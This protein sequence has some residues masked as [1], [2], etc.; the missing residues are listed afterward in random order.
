MARA[1]PMWL[2]LGPKDE[3]RINAAELSEKEL[4]DEVH[5]LTHFSQEDSIPLTSSHVPFDADHPP[6]EN[7]IDPDYLQ[8]LPNDTSER[9]DSSVP[10]GSHTEGNASSKAEHADPIN[11]EAILIDPKSAAN[12][13]SDTAGSM[14]DDDADHAAFVDAAAEEAEALPSKRSSGGF[15]DEDDL[16][17]LD[18]DFIEPPPKKSKTSAAPS[19]LAASEPSA[20]A[21]VPVAQ[22]STSSSLSKGKN[23]PSVAAAATPPSGK[24]DLRAVISSLESFASQYASLEVDKAQLQKEVESSS[25]K[26]EGAIKIVAEA[27]TEIDT[28]KEELEVLKR[29][30]KDEEVARLT[31]E[32]RAMEK[33][34][35]LRQSSLAL[36]RD[37]D[38]PVE[39]LDELY[40]VPSFVDDS[41]GALPESDRLQRMRDRV[42]KMEKDMRNTYAL[43]AIVNKKNELAA[44]TERYALT[45]LHKA[46]ESLNSLN[47][48]DENKRIHKHVHAL[49]QLSSAD[50]VFWREQAKASTVAKFQDRVQQVHRFFDKV[51]KALRVIW[52]TMFPLNAVPPTLLTLMSEFSNAKKIRDLVRAQVFEG[53]RFT[54]ALVLARYPSTNLLS[55]AKAVGDLELLYPKVMLPANMIV[56]KIEKD[57]KEPEEKDTPQE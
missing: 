37:A 3:T 15:A 33:D 39:A 52:K 19:D 55:I 49:T 27:R 11:P 48:A 50:E 9:G 7:P 45:E 25:S 43:A 20:P 1:H 18:E 56:D 23:I 12:D 2:Y 44:D 41:S 24:P 26:L 21:T 31:A 54:L 6:T 4:L 42:T 51:Y 28:L 35:L 5:R 30:L 34:D 38:I 17:D 57:S 22:I 10:V 14:H 46:T 53:A 47:K 29:R 16:W 13:I 32:A 40:P 8:D 36:L